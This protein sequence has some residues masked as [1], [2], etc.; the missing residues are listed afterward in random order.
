MKE[1]LK[2]GNYLTVSQ[3]KTYLKDTPKM[4]LEG[5]TRIFQED[6]AQILVCLFFDRL[7]VGTA[8]KAGKQDCGI[9]YFNYWSRLSS[10][11]ASI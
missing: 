7:S 9:P 11:L 4:S 2:Y 8:P 5:S 10:S 3:A 1:A 6:M